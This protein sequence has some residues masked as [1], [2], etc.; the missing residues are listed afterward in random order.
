[1]TD[2]QPQEK[3]RTES[4]M[5]FEPIAEQAPEKRAPKSDTR[6]RP[7]IRTRRARLRISRVDPWSVMKTSFLFSIAAG[8]MMWV[9]VYVLWTLIGAS[10]MIEA[11]NGVLTTLLSSDQ[12]MTPTRVEDFV[13]T[14]KLMG[15]T[16]VA[17]VANVII[18]TALGTIFAFLYNLSATILGG[19]ELT[20]A[21][22]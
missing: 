12:N 15:F 9:A 1:M 19:L 5:E 17:A 3:L 11:I 4:G 18:L 20:L 8:I 13:N 22:D 10:G 16:T 7:S 14:N 2:T 6:P 21:E